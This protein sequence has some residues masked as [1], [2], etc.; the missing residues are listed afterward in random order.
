MGSIVI[1]YALPIATVSIVHI[2]ICTKLRYRARA[3]IIASSKDPTK[4][5]RDGQR[6]RKTNQLLIAIA[7][8]FGICWMPL[9][10]FNVS[11]DAFNFFGEDTQT[12][13]VSYAFCHM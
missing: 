1:Q 7:I 5:Q 4:Q 12:M 2:R 3:S 8:I 9:N 6:L 10:F 11:V 13:L